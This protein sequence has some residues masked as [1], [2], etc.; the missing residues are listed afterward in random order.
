MVFLFLTMAEKL[1][2]LST[3]IGVCADKHE[4]KAN[5]VAN[6]ISL[7]LYIIFNPV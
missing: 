5:K 7:V 3:G 6:N 4:K 2:A 1:N